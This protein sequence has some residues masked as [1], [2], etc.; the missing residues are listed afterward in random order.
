MSIQPRNSTKMEELHSVIRLCERKI[1]EME[2]ET[3]MIR[4]CKQQL[5]EV[6][7][8]YEKMDGMHEPEEK[9][10]EE[11]KHKQ[12]QVF[13]QVMEKEARSIWSNFQEKGMDQR[14]DYMQKCLEETGGKKW[15]EHT[16]KLVD[17]VVKEQKGQIKRLREDTDEVDKKTKKRRLVHPVKRRG[18]RPLQNREACY[19]TL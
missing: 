5:E 7:F 13:L 4:L 8:N 15:R 1:E 14:S 19:Y 10:A 3:S 18:V 2:N 9:G 6:T 11:K 16:D 12:E 17:Y